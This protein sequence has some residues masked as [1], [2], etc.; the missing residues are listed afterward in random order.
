VA[1]SLPS[2][3]PPHQQ[4]P[5]RRMSAAGRGR[6][7]EFR[8]EAPIGC[9]FNCS[10]TADVRLLLGDRTLHA[11]KL[12]LSAAS[13]VF[14]A[15]LTGDW[16]ESGSGCV[17]LDLA[18]DQ[19]GCFADVL[20][21][22][23]TG[24]VILDSAERLLEVHRLADK[25]AVSSLL[26][27]C[28]S[29]ISEL[30]RIGQTAGP[31]S[32]LATRGEFSPAQLCHLACLPEPRISRLAR[33]NL[34]VDIGDDLRRG[35]TAA[36]FLPVPAELPDLLERLLADDNLDAP[37]VNIFDGLAAWLLRRRP[38]LD[39]PSLLR[40][41]GCVRFPLM[42]AGQLLLC[43]RRLRRELLPLTGPLPRT[44]LPGTKSSDD[45]AE[46]AGD[47][48]AAEVSEEELDADSAE[49]EGSNSADL[50]RLLGPAWRH[51]ALLS[52]SAN[53]STSLSS[54]AFRRRHPYD[55]LESTV[56]PL[57][58]LLTPCSPPD[59]GGGS[60]GGSRNATV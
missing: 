52:A 19:L 39:R 60:G 15:M 27:L 6:P 25:Y 10:Q 43:E 35:R 18:D 5:H 26:Q 41:L 12:V 47:V 51:L 9:L 2:D 57:R 14:R 59:V 33:F 34:L 11:H 38:R 4:S 50:Y 48:I 29:R 8:A 13:P 54:P 49:A 36:A 55:I 32:P 23:Y 30:L 21:F 37:E 7:G 45:A 24:R 3:S 58:V 53:Q 17:R 46:P 28:G 44:P 42:P 56:R 20:R 16:L 40:L 1:A 31:E 22:M